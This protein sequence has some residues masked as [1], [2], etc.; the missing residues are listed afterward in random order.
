M[1]DAPHITKAKEALE[2]AE[3]ATEGPWEI[4]DS[5]SWRRIGRTPYQRDGDVLCPTN[6]TDGHPDLLATRETLAFIAH[7][8]Q[9][10]PYLA[11]KVIELDAEV[12]R[13]KMSLKCALPFAKLK[14]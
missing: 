5:C 1:T 12:E 6:Q 13:L 7:A 11:R 14:Q 3:K 8:R 10:V 4:Q 2:R 9:D